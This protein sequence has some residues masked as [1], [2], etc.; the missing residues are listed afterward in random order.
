[1]DKFKCKRCEREFESYNSLRK[2]TSRIHKIKSSDFYVEFYLDGVYPLCKCGCGKNV[3][4]SPYGKFRE[5]AAAG[6]SNKIHNNWGHNPKAIFKSSE[7]RR[8]QYENGERKVWNDGLTSITDKRVRLNAE[9]SK[10]AINSNQEELKKRSERMSRLRKD[11]TIPTLYREQSSQWKGGVSSIQQLARGNKR[12]YEEWKFPI[13]KEGKFKCKECKCTEDLHVHH[14]KETFSEIIKKVMTIEDYENIDD[15]E[16]KKI[17][18]EKIID[19]HVQNKVSGKV[20]CKV[21]HNKIHP[22]LN[23]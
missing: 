15:F 21:C 22:S 5:Y 8:K 10:K 6:H 4:W 7:T 18:V 16:R 23:F 20:L 17:I 2:H 19:Y 9:S 12:L 11:G 13:L 14:D 3:K 1:M